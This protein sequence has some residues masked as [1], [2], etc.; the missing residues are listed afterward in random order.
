MI[1]YRIQLTSIPT[2]TSVKSTLSSC[3]ALPKRW[4]LSNVFLIISI[5][6]ARFKEIC[7][8]EKFRRQLLSTR[9]LSDL[10]WSRVSYWTC[11]SKILFLWLINYSPHQKQTRKRLHINGVQKIPSFRLSTTDAHK[12]QWFPTSI[13]KSFRIWKKKSNEFSFEN[14]TYDETLDIHRQCKILSCSVI[15]EYW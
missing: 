2:C 12:I 6:C 1:Q 7:F 3:R 5:L 13:K 15:K 8:F 14:H 11:I 10:F 9:R 4:S